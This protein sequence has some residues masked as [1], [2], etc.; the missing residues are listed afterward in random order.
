MTK[1]EL[2]AIEER[3]K[4]GGHRYVMDEDGHY[5]L[6]MDDRGDLDDV[7]ALLFEVGRLRAELAALSGAWETYPNFDLERLEDGRY[8][9][10]AFEGKDPLGNRNAWAVGVTPLEAVRALAAKWERYE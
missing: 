4:Y 5:K 8:E 2:Q 1:E 3:W 6:D 10:S 7:C 9:A